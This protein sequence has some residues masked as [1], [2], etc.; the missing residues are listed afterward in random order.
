MIAELVVL[1]AILTTMGYI[2]LKGSLVKSFVLFMCSLI[3]AV[4]AL[5]F[6]ETA[7]RMVIGYGYGGQWI[8]TGMLILI[9][10][11]T[12][13]VLMIVAEKA[14]PFEL[15]F[16][17]LPDRIGK[18]LLAI[19]TGLI[20][21]GVLL[22]AVNLSPLPVKWP[23][24]RYKADNIVGLPDQPDKSL[25]LN[26]DGFTASLASTISKGSMSGK[27]SLAVFHPLLVNELSL[28][29][30]VKDESNPI[31][32]GNN[33]ITVK[34]AV[35][36]SDILAEKIRK[37]PGKKPIIVQVEIR[38][39][40]VKEGGA[41][42]TVESGTVT[43]TFAQVRLICT[44][45]PDSFKG[46]GELAFPIGWL[47]TDG[48]ITAKPFKEEIKLPGS[49]FP[50]GTKTIDFIFNVPTGKTPALLQ[51]K[52]NGVAEITR[53]KKADETEAAEQTK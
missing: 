30:S 38:N 15:F 29:R 21:S 51:F 3:A 45:A 11:I 18:C 9:F 12:F 16:G 4:V 40:L 48:S 7:G 36:A 52:I 49:D 8:F 53:V 27:K 42:Y 37:E 50:N 13:I 14:E 44:D 43:F 31:I 20:I 28:N 10:A 41:L 35:W 34:S 6:F 33:A 47:N 46:A 2:Y 22:I 26:A 1:A 19:P 25:I 17:D 39:S 24:E 5:S 23:Y 32:T